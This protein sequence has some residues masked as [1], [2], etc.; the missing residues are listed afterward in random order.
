MFKLI[1]LNSTVML[2]GYSQGL[3]IKRKTVLSRSRFKVLLFVTYSITQ[4]TVVK[5]KSGQV[6]SM[7]SAKY[8]TQHKRIYINIG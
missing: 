6:R 7:D 5:Y 4:N 8:I 1:A 2:N 3:N